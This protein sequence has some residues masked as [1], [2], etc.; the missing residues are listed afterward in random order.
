MICYTYDRWGN[1]TGE[2]VH[3]KYQPLP[4]CYTEVKPPAGDYAVW[5][6]F[7]WELRAA[8][9]APPTPPAPTLEQQQ[10]A[11]AEAY[12][13][14]SDP[15]FFE[16]QRGEALASDWEAKVAEIRDRFPYPVE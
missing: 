1:Y 3:V 10:A 12:R 16:S 2:H 14:E 15:I 9:V 5:D 7:A 6:G 13:T 8:P 11:R 4:P